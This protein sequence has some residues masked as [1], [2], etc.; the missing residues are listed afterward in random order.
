MSGMVGYLSEFV[1]NLPLSLT[2][3]EF[4]KLVNI[5]GSYGHEFNALFFFDS[6][7]RTTTTTLI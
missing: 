4:W 5:S 3:K 2:A 6:Q 1:A 7:S